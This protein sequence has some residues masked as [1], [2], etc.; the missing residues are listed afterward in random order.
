MYGFLLLIPFF[1]IWFGLLS[2]LN[3][4]AVQRAA[5]FAP[6]Y[7]NEKIPYWIY[8]ISN[9]GIVIYALFATVKIEYTWLF[10]LGLVC[11]LLGLL[12]CAISIVNFSSPSDV[13]MNTNG[14]YRFSRNPMYVSYF[15][16]FV[17]MA[18]LTQSL[19]LLGM[20]VIFQISAHWIILS[21]ERWCLETFGLPYA[22]YMKKVR[23]YL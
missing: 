17:G 2:Y 9:V 22:Q 16:C 23:R 7:G 12:L 19:V 14:I 1:L 10:V 3:K 6:M 20:V 4:R 18:A 8:Q 15:V 11:Y 21:E 5:H 13:G